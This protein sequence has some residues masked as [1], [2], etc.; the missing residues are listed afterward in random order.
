MPTG[1]STTAPRGTHACLRITGVARV[2]VLVDPREPGDDRG[3][4]LAQRLV[5]LQLHP[6]EGGDDLAG[7]VV[8]RRPEP[9][10]G[11]DEHA[12]GRRAVAQSLGEVVGPVAD[13]EQ[14][15]DLETRAVSSCASHDPFASA[16]TP[17]T[18]SLPVSTTAA[19]GRRPPSSIGS[20]GRGAVARP[21]SPSP[22]Q[23]VRAVFPHTAYR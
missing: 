13:A 12:A 16:I 18:S 6:G 5:E 4:P 10:A 1:S 15:R 9:A 3:D 8:G 17:V 21:V 20:Q 23:S 22:F 7:Q 19:R 11:D 2:R 14:M